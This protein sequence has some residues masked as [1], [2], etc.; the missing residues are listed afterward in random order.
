MNINDVTNLFDKKKKVEK[1]INRY[2]KLLNL[3]KE[4]M[5]QESNDNESNEI[6]KEE[7][8]K[9][10]EATNIRRNKEIRQK[11]E[12]KINGLN[13]NK[14]KRKEIVIKDNQKKEYR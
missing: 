13:L 5:S 7:K 4:R 2:L 6:K 11:E 1:K 3:I 12:D 10:N 14:E 9:G 8:K